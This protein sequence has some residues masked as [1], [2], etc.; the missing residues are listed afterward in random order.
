MNI[1]HIEYCECILN[2]CVCVCVCV[3]VWCNFLFHLSSVLHTLHVAIV[4]CTYHVH[5]ATNL[6]VHV[7]YMCTIE[8]IF[9]SINVQ[10]TTIGYTN[11][12]IAYFLRLAFD[13]HLCCTCT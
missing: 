9:Y 7:Q 4:T 3:C 2:D 6:K 10:L 11:T 5:V 13:V 12:C 8:E 1:V